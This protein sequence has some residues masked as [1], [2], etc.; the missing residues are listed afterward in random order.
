MISLITLSSCNTIDNQSDDFLNLQHQNQS[1]QQEIA[2][3]A[4][5]EHTL[6][7][8]EEAISARETELVNLLAELLKE[9]KQLELYKDELI[10]SKQRSAARAR[11]RARVTPAPN[12][13][14]TNQDSNTKKSEQTVLGELENVYLDPPG[15]QFSARIDTG[16]QTSSLNAMDLVEFERDGK[17]YVKFHINHPQTNKKIELTRRVRGYVGIIEH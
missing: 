4:A 2:A 1:M 13:K 3:Y 17:P 12:N 14:T 5:R 16:A 9:K 8:R 10:L 15:M 6:T 7:S 11:A